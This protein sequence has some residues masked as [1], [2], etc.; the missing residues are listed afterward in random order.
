MSL[1]SHGAVPVGSY[2]A[3]GLLGL[4]HM[5]PVGRSEYSCIDDHR[6]VSTRLQFRRFRH[7]LESLQR[8]TDGQKLSLRTRLCALQAG[9]RVSEALG[10]IIQW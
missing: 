4:S 9:V 6:S 2:G 7:S 8:P 5:E 10:G 1:R 3:Y